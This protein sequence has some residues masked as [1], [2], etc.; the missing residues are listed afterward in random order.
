MNFKVTTIINTLVLMLL[1]SIITNVKSETNALGQQITVI[2]QKENIKE[3]KNTYKFSIWT[4]INNGYQMKE[5]P[6]RR[7]RNFEKWYSSRPEYVERMLTRSEKY[8]F[9]VVSEVEKRNMPMEIALLPMIE[10]AYNPIATSR[11]KAAGMWQFIPS[12]GKIYGLEQNWWVDNRR[13]VMEAT[14]AALNYLEKLHKEFGTWELALASYNAGEGRVGRAIKRNKRNKKP[15]GYYSLRLPRETKNYV[16]KLFAIKN[17]ISNPRKYGLNLPKIKNQPYFEVVEVN[18]NIDTQL[19]A[20]LAEISIE[21]FRL[22][23]PQHKRPV[24]NVK[25]VP[26]KINLPYQKI[27]IFNYNLHSYDKPLSNWNSYNPKKKESVAQVAKKFGIDRKILI[28]VNRLERRKSFRRN[29]TI[30][31]PNKDAITTYFPSNVNELYNYSS[32][33]THKVTRG[34]TLSHISDK[35]NISVRD[36]KEFNELRSDRIIIGDTLDIPK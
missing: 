4:R 13:T 3:T 26:L 11:Q 35:Y 8:L 23:N 12:T 19:I 6:S 34:Q 16:P 22:L 24:I 7:I 21:E 20:R 18:K 5:K 2:G 27:H 17:I 28:Q 14:N 10:S 15:T 29:S 1:L 9:Y 25:S 30:L 33:I 36:I 32:I 31:I